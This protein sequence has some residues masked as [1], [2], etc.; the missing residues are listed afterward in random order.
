[1]EREKEV[2][3]AHSKAEPGSRKGSEWSLEELVE[4]NFL[5]NQDRLRFIQLLE[6]VVCEEQLR[7]RHRGSELMHPP[8]SETVS[9]VSFPQG[10][11]GPA[12][13][14]S[15]RNE[16]SKESGLAVEDNTE[17]L[18]AVRNALVESEKEREMIRGQLE[19]LREEKVR[20]MR[21]AK[22]AEGNPESGK[23]TGNTLSGSVSELESRISLM[24][25][26]LE[27]ERQSNREK[28][29]A[30]EGYKEMERTMVERCS[31]LEM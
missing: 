30:I 11:E 9:L 25:G 3:G 14:G 7:P 21:E 6:S 12:K 28:M 13:S 15:R 16:G 26:E 18:A 23:E 19:V 8:F 1:M 29:K 4:M 27:E 22:R 24:K 31:E 2:P 17:D 5:L 20:D 10:L